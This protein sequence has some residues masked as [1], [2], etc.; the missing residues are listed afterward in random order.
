MPGIRSGRAR[1]QSCR[2][3]PAKWRLQPL[4]YALEG[5]SVQLRGRSAIQRRVKHSQ[6]PGLQPSAL[7]PMLSEAES[8]K[9]RSRAGTTP[10]RSGFP[11][12]SPFPQL[13]LSQCSTYLYLGPAILK[14]SS[15]SATEPM[16][17]R[18][19]NSSRIKI[20]PLTCCSP[21]IFSQFPANSLSAEDQGGGG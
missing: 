19:P 21:K 5:N 7:A 14:D 1:L 17:P 2:I 8:S 6:Q 12:P 4:R 18:T 9:G 13:F 3:K 20:L 15:G 10:S 16:P 11:P